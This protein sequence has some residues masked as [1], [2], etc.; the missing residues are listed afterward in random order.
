[1]PIIK[2]AITNCVDPTIQ[3][4]ID[5][6]VSATPVY[7]VYGSL[8]ITEVTYISQ[9]ETEETVCITGMTY[10]YSDDETFP[11]DV[12]GTIVDQYNGQPVYEI[13]V[14]WVEYPHTVYLLFNSTLNRWEV[15]RN[16]INGEPSCQADSGDTSGITNTCDL[17]NF[18]GAE[19]NEPM[20]HS[21]TSDLTTTT[22][23][24]VTS[25]CPYTGVTGFSTITYCEVP[26]EVTHE[27]TDCWG[28]NRLI[29]P[30]PLIDGTYFLQEEFDNCQDCLHPPTTIA[31]NCETEE[32]LYLP[33][34][35][36][37]GV[38]TNLDPPQGL[39]NCWQLEQGVLPEGQEITPAINITNLYQRCEDCLPAPPPEP[40]PINCDL[41]EL[42]RLRDCLGRGRT[43]YSS[44]ETLEEFVGKVVRSEYY[45]DCFF[46]D[47]AEP[48]TEQTYTLNFEVDNVHENCFD[49]LPQ[50]PVD[51]WV[52]EQCCDEETTQEVTC[53]FSEG[54]Y[55]QI[56]E[57][58]F[59]IKITEN[60][61]I[62]NNGIRF[63]SLRN[64]LLCLPYPPLP[65]PRVIEP[66]IQI[67]TP[68]VPK[69]NNCH[70]CNE[71]NTVEREPCYACSDRECYNYKVELRTEFAEATG[72]TNTWLNERILFA[73]FPCG[74]K[75]SRTVSFTE[76]TA[77]I[78]CVLGIPILGYYKDNEFVEVPIERGGECEPPEETDCGCDQQRET[79]TEDEQRETLIR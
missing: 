40:L 11:E 33:P 16:F 53:N 62:T 68:C 38:I 63:E 64:K 54:I 59:G 31:T 26:I 78:F 27:T 32:V 60:S 56:I 50:K 79:L 2:V 25:P 29:V 12:T 35:D 77:E 14:N 21:Q 19:L 45:D 23:V 13:P 76:S 3:L 7:P 70:G 69:Q 49:C 41:I 36:V 67:Q 73:Y 17:C 34:G 30:L 48:S 43:I 46:V 20:L 51:P 28:I 22:W 66:C 57:A 44:D 5:L 72:N 55:K 1:M 58:R 37:S 71:P 52:N 42:Y 10:Q 74:K 15:W 18:G 65:E 75:E 8:G 39:V 9:T 4:E 47:Q 61:I 24:Q 6:D